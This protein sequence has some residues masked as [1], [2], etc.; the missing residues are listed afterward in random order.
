VARIDDRKTQAMDV[1]RTVAAHYARPDIE[2]A[3]LDALRA[4]GKDPDRIAA[5]D[6]SAADAFHLGWHAVTLDLV[7]DL[8][9]G[10][11]DHLLDIGSGIGGAARTF[12]D[13]TG[14]RV[15]GIDL[16]EAYV[17]AAIALTRRCGLSDRVTFRQASALD[18]PFD[19]GTFDAATLIH[20]GMN[21]ADKAGLFAQ[22]RRV[23]KSGGLFC[24]YE[25]MRVGD[26]DIP[27]PM[28][29]AATA[30]TS[31]VETPAAYRRHLEAAGFAVDAQTDRS[32][33]VAAIGRA[34]RAAA[35]STG[36]PPLGLHLL[37][38]PD[39]R[40]RTANVM[41]ALEAGIIAPVQMM[42]RAV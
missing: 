39:V 6:L 35:T 30:E 11:D 17:E 42:A 18:L 38:G 34:M 8:A 32:A 23:L 2:A 22:A 29:W 25:V 7:A 1:E 9:P 19:A 26:A 36:V 27:Y 40:A 21:I 13:R 5:S 12:A 33:Q 15:T 4:E 37:I 31:F 10:R 14:C 20:V 16:T 24:L 3:I 41:A 28:P